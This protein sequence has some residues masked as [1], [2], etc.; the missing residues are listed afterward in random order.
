MKKDFLF[1][2]EKYSAKNNISIKTV[3]IL[4]LTLFSIL[5]STWFLFRI[6][7]TIIFVGLTTIYYLF[8]LLFK[9]YLVSS[10][11]TI[12]YL[13]SLLFKLYLVS[14]SK[15]SDILKISEKDIKN[16][17]NKKLPYYS[18]LIPLYREKEIVKQL[19]AEIKN[20]DWPKNK[21]DVKILLEEDDKDTIE[22]IKN[23]KLPNYFDIII[24]P[25]SY[26]KTK[27]K[28]LNVGMLRIKGKYIT[29]YDAEDKPEKDQ[30]KKAY[31][32]FQKL[33]YMLRRL[34]MKILSIFIL[35][36]PFIFYIFSLYTGK[37][38]KGSKFFSLWKM[39]HKIWPY[40][41]TLCSDDFS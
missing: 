38:H 14:N 35:L 37:S 39:E 26:P 19:L 2:P 34:D 12:Y 3:G 40:Y 31:L 11:T 1:I 20:M 7:P 13:F 25:N 16:I 28:A 4:L 6:N 8:S 5:L 21:L 10:L 23:E 24:I 18:I 30:L 41:A 27:P 15:N 33:P 36:T 22:Y 29:I 17:N 9:L 32:S